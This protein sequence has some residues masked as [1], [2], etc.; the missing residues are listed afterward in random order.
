MV[1]V[2]GKRHQSGA[3]MECATRQYEWEQ[4]FPEKCVH[5]VNTRTEVQYLTI[6]LIYDVNDGLKT[7][8]C[9]AHIQQERLR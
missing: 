7:C 6:E 1:A 2:G 3:I 5:Y 4:S 8:R 9:D